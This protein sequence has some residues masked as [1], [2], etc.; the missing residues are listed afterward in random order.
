MTKL[1]NYLTD[2]E[3]EKVFNMTRKEFEQ[4]PVWKQQKEKRA[5]NLF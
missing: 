3:F 4:F 1:E 5:K 2:E